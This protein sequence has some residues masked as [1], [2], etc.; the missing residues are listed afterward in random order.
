MAGLP[1]ERLVDLITSA[2]GGFYQVHG[3]EDY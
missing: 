1:K 3:V 2:R